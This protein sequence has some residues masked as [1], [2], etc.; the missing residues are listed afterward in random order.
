LSSSAEER[1]RELGI[2]L[3]GVAAPVANY[4]PA[5]TAGN[6]VFLSGGL[7]VRPDG[8]RPAGKVG[9]EVSIEEAYA[10]AR[11]AA[12]GLLARLRAETGSLD[13]VRRIVKLTGFVNAAPDFESQPQV[14]NGASD[15]L[16]EVF[17]EAGRHARSAIGVGSLPFNAPVEVELVAEIEA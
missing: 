7:A 12:L 16:V 15:L 4:V 10:A 13:R 14:I 2:E 17:G 11:L 3:P 9:S 8:T 5:V 6:L 1:L